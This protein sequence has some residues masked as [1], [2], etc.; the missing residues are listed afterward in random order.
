MRKKLVP[1]KRIIG[2]YKSFVPWFKGACSVS[3]FAVHF[4]Y[5]NL[6]YLV[7]RIIAGIIIKG[8]LGTGKS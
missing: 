8:S 7:S 5:I 3:F 4:R 1:R 6:E 2:I